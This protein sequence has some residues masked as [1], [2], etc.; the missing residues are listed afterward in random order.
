MGGFPIAFA[1]WWRADEEAA[2]DHA[3]RV[4]QEQGGDLRRTYAEL[5]V[6]YQSAKSGHVRTHAWAVFLREETRRVREA[7][8]AYRRV[9]PEAR[10]SDP[11]MMGWR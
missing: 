1:D 7:R 8:T 9:V 6:R 4:V 3:R 5:G 2:R 10:V 11:G